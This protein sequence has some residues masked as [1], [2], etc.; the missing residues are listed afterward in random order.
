[1]IFSV[2]LAEMLSNMMSKVLLEKFKSSFV[3]IYY[4]MKKFSTIEEKQKIQWIET[5]KFSK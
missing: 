2:L 5:L 3:K 1:M 4:P